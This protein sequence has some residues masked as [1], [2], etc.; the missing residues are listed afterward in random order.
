M[1]QI[2]GLLFTVVIFSAC[3]SAKKADQIALKNIP[4]HR[5]VASSQTFIRFL[6][7]ISK[8]AKI[9]QTALEESI[10]KYIKDPVVR[11]GHRNH[12]VLGITDDQA[13]RIS[14]LSDDLPY[15]DKVRKWVTE[16]IT[17]IN[18][19]ISRDI[20][21]EVFETI[22]VQS[23]GIKNPY[24]LVGSHIESDARSMIRARQIQ[25]SPVSV[26]SNKNQRLLNDLEDIVDSSTKKIYQ[27]NLDQ[28][29]ARSKTDPIALAN[30]QEIVESAVLITR[31]TGHR[32]MGEGCEE[33]SKIA[34]LDILEAKANVDIYRSRLVEDMAHAKAGRTFA[35][36]D[37]IPAA[38]RLTQDELDSAT[39]K[40]FQ[41]VLGY[42][43]DEA[44]LALSRLKKKPCKLY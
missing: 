20:A 2:L 28:F 34:S 16:N 14:S 35:S 42:T 39:R 6:Q 13:R 44:H 24:R 22:I 29:Q 36:V 38:A 17:L 26:L 41:D 40:A 32:A 37:D 33:F 4:M 25:S 18:R 10:L 12:I 15:M 27:K 19:N 21:E 7:K 11:G 5:S 43:D 31:K 3:Q 30:G 23:R 8:R 1:N 9:P